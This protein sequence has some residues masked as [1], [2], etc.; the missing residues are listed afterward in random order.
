MSIDPSAAWFHWRHYHPNLAE[1]PRAAFAA[2]VVVGREQMLEASVEWAQLP[3]L[4]GSLL[5]EL[6]RLREER[7]IE[8]EIVASDTREP[9]PAF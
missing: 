2:G 3:P 5:E 4:L 1:D 8:R 6:V 7:A 9:E